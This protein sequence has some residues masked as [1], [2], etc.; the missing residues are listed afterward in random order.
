MAEP[1]L[2]GQASWL[3]YLSTLPDPASAFAALVHGPLHHYGARAGG[4]WKLIDGETLERLAL[5]GHSADELSRHGRIPLRLDFA[6][7]RA[8]RANAFRSAETETNAR[9]Y[10]AAA[11]DESMWQRVS[12]RLNAKSIGNVPIRYDG[13][14]VGAYG[15]ICDRHVSWTEADETALLGIG[16]AL[17]LWLTHP[18]RV[19]IRPSAVSSDEPSIAL[20]TRQEQVLL[21]VEQGMP[22]DSIA[23]SLRYSISTIKADLGYAMRMLHTDDREVAASRARALG[24]FDDDAR[25][26]EAAT[27]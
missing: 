17:G 24:L 7:T 19:K 22:T 18:Q 27:R 10:R 11:L 20:T 23:E 5:Y 9:D 14:I 1:A 16:S 6:I 21:L 3:Q 26:H 25:P 15:F 8:V 13:R 4:I 12:E 2:P